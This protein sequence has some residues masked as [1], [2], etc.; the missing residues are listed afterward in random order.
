MV[1]Y[2]VLQLCLIV[3]LFALYAFVFVVIGLISQ[4]FI[5]DGG[6]SAI[7]RLSELLPVKDM[8]FVLQLILFS[9]RF[10]LDYT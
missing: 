4:P 9:F 8:A 5:S 3:D 2:D 10:S 6:V 1:F 7:Y